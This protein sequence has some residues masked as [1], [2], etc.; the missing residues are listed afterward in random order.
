M[1]LIRLQRVVVV[2]SG[3]RGPAP[4]LEI[5]GGEATEGRAGKTTL[6]TFTVTK[7]GPTDQEVTVAYADAGT[8]GTGTATA[9]TDYT[10]VTAGTLTFEPA[11][12][13]KTITVMVQG[14]RP[15][16]T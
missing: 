11:E 15:V 5:R 3:R 13:S 8:A 6:L 7:S 4:T 1:A 2:V 14:R 16:R 12:T 9:G 10:A